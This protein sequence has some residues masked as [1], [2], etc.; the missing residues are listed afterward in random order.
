MATQQ[1]GLSYLEKLVLASCIDA[2]S[3]R[4]HNFHS[5]LI[6]DVV[7]SG[8]VLYV[9][10]RQGKITIKDDDSDKSSEQSEN[11]QSSNANEP[12]SI[13]TLI[14]KSKKKIEDNNIKVVDSSD[15]NIQT[16][17]DENDEIINEVFRLISCLYLG[18]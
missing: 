6:L 18:L 1:H 7:L 12:L 16:A 11:S 8:A 10:T 4:V 5:S 3:A 9:L 2:Q 15:A 13:Q 14:Q 17:D